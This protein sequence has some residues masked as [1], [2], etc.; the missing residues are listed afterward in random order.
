MSKQLREALGLVASSE[1]AGTG[2]LKL[3]I[4]IMEGDVQG[5][6]GYYPAKVLREDGPKI[7]VKGTHMHLDHMSFWDMMEGSPGKLDTLAGFLD[8]D[9]VYETGADGV[10]GLYADAIVISQY[11]K[12]IQEVQENIGVSILAAAT[13]EEGISPVTKEPTDIITGFV[14]VRSIDFV[15]HPGANGR[16]VKQLNESA[17][18]LWTPGYETGVKF[19]SSHPAIESAGETKKEKKPMAEL[20]EETAAA[21][22]SAIEAQT[23]AIT[24]AETARVAAEAAKPKDAPVDVAEVIL[25]LTTKLA[26][27]ELPK[28]AHAKV[29]QSIKAGVDADEA[30]ASEKAY[31]ESLTTGYTKP[32][33]GGTTTREFGSFPLTLVEGGNGDVPV[34][35][36]NSWMS[37]Y[38]VKGVS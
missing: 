23:A 28:A 5:S 24:A 17:K 16:I 35:P 10:E 6:S 32:T 36:D 7:F 21:L 19:I 27:S 38:G 34:K 30:I 29:M 4:R 13:S 2:K 8:S 11:S 15:T 9:A 12:F 18:T 3:R 33:E 25:A 20:T 14:G 1:T 37:A 31:I 26:E 22:K